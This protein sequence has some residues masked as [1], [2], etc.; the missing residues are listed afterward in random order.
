VQ[1]AFAGPLAETLGVPPLSAAEEIWRGATAGEGGAPADQSGQLPAL[2]DTPPSAAEVSSGRV[3]LPIG[4]GASRVSIASNGRISQ[5]PDALPSAEAIG[6][7]H[8]TLHKLERRSD[9]D[10]PPPPSM[11][12]PSQLRLLTI[13]SMMLFGAFLIAGILRSLSPK[14]DQVIVIEREPNHVVGV[15]GAGAA[16][17]APAE[18]AEAL[19]EPPE[20]KAPPA[21]P[22]SQARSRAAADGAPSAGLAQKISAES[23]VARPVEPDP[24]L[25]TWHFALEEGRVQGCFAAHAY[26]S[27]AQAELSVEFQVSSEGKVER[28][29]LLPANAV[30]PDLRSCVLHVAKTTHFPRLTRAVTFRIPIQTRVKKP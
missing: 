27:D 9:S 20:D 1:V 24:K 29:E 6:S 14:Q 8:P 13:L 23:S 11:L 4:T 21:K 28:A 16:N 15:T 18:Q 22:E 3:A 10:Q 25:L 26:A 12:K 30:S 19:A 5:F 7:E 17:V 2:T